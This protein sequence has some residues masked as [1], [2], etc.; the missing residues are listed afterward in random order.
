MLRIFDELPAGLLDVD[1]LDLADALGGPS[2]IRVAGA[3][4]QPLLVAT[5]LHGNET[6]GWHAL[7]HLL[8]Q[9]PGGTLPRPLLLFIGN[10]DAA[11][12][13]L[14][15]LDSQPDFNRIW[16]DAVGPEAAMAAQVLAA[17]RRMSPFACIDVHNT[18]GENPVYA[19]VHRLDGPA[20]AL[21]GHFASTGVLISHPESLL[22]MA[23]APIA[24]SITLECGKPGNAEVARQ[25]ARSLV[26]L[27]ALERLPDE[28]RHGDGALQLLRTVARVRV[29]DRVSFSFQEAA[30]D[31]RFA[32]GLDGFNFAVMPAGTTIAEVGADAARGHGAVL[33]ATDEHGGD[34]SERFFRRRGDT[35]VTATPWIPSLFTG[36]ERIVRQDCLCYVMEPI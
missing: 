12:E 21:A 8:R 2:L 23:L 26:D 24:P 10:V 11:R 15:H 7:R 16:C 19:C 22:S 4:G 6:T 27:M 9:H 30:V 35:L 5:L 28:V 17:A 31:L 33:L 20:L 13:G 3:R 32:R 29:P 1:A 36:D 34:L 25:I 18:S 14:R